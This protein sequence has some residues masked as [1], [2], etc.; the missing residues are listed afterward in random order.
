MWPVLLVVFFLSSGLTVQSSANNGDRPHPQIKLTVKAD[1]E[2]YRLSENI[3]FE[4]RHTN[5][6]NE[7]VYLFDDDCWGFADGLTLWIYDSTGKRSPA[8]FRLP[9]RLHSAPA[10]T[11]RHE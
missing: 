5:L 8:R 2:T 11:W 10:K 9:S 1:R 7:D 6:G 4:T 3:D